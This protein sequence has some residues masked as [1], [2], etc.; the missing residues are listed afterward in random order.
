MVEPDRRR[1]QAFIDE[2]N[3][4]LDYRHMRPVVAADIGAVVDREADFEYFIDR[5]VLPLMIR[6]AQRAGITLFFVRVQRRPEGGRPPGQSDA[7][8]RYVARLRE[9][10]L[11]RGALWRDDTGDAALTIDLYSDGDHLAREARPRYTGLFWNRVHP[12]LQ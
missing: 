3:G 1:R 9:Y 5:S 12:L 6:D 4:R 10:V 2:M 8:R 11:L 7:L